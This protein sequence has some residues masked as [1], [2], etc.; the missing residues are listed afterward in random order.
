MFNNCFTEEKRKTRCPSC[1]SSIVVQVEEEPL[2]SS[3]CNLNQS[4][5]VVEQNLVE[6][7]YSNESTPINSR[8]SKM[9][10]A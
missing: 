4:S 7:E 3:S 9:A 5:E 10:N 1:D 6:E 2:P 8:C